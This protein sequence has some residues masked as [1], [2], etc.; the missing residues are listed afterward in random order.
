M[1]LPMVQEVMEGGG[2]EVTII[3]GQ[4]TEQQILEVEVVELFGMMTLMV[5][6][7]VQVVQVS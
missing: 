4:Q 6:K 7:V 1:I 2:M 5:E 3:L